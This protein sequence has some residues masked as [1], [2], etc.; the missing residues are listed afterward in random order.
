MNIK[1]LQEKDQYEFFEFLYNGLQLNLIIGID[2]TSSNKELKNPAKNLHTEIFKHNQYVK[3][4]SCVSSILL[5][6]DDDKLVPIY[7]FGKG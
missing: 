7:G 4:I 2:Y 5:D 1:N 6:Y 3:A